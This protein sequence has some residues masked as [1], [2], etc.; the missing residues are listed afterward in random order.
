MKKILF[1][2]FLLVLL[3]SFTSCTEEMPQEEEK[4]SAVITITDPIV[5]SHLHHNDT[6]H[7]RGSI[8]SVMDLHGYE[9][10]IRRTDNQMEVYF[11]DDHYHGTNKTLGLD[12]PCNINVDVQLELAITVRLDHDGSATQKSVKFFCEP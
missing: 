8:T 12:W 1:P 2:T 11:Y 6:L 7:I 9:T 10:S 4:N 3:F 5:D